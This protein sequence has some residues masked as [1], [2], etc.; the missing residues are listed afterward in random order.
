MLK[1]FLSPADTDEVLG[2]QTNDHDSENEELVTSFAS[3]EVKPQT[4]EKTEE[5][6]ELVQRDSIYID[7][8]KEVLITQ[9]ESSQFTISVIDT[10]MLAAD[11]DEDSSAE[12]LPSGPESTNSSPPPEIVVQEEEEEEEETKKAV[13]AATLSPPP[14]I[15]VVDESVSDRQPNSADTTTTNNNT[16]PSPTSGMI[17]PTRGSPVF[18]RRRPT[19][20]G[21]RV[22]WWLK[23]IIL[24]FCC[25]GF[26]FH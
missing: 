21:Y 23:A 18:D 2:P 11:N 6:P 26:I 24:S 20:K 10:S 13:D 9:P 3:I 17:S 4:E 15:T 25:R 1:I 8:I 12:D 5:P 22:T 16:S 19:G 7:D 14:S